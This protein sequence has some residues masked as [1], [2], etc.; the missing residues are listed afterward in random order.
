ML[1]AADRR[2]V[3]DAIHFHAVHALGCTTCKRTV[4]RVDAV[5]ALADRVLN[6]DNAKVRRHAT[7]ALMVRSADPRVRAVLRKVA[8][9]DADERV[10]RDATWATR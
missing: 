9:T 7:W 4:G 1:T 6:D 5:P 3:L 10:R 8:T 2:S